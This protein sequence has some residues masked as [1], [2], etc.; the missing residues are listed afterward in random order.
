MR[1][2]DRK[3]RNLKPLAPGSIP[4]SALQQDISYEDWTPEPQP[5]SPTTSNFPNTTDSPRTHVSFIFFFF[6]ML[7]KVTGIRKF[8]PRN[9]N[10]V[11]LLISCYKVFIRKEMSLFDEYLRYF[12]CVYS[13]GTATNSRPPGGVSRWSF[14]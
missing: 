11:F 6:R 3:C 9:A 14:Q 1:R 12:L 8:E 4:L 5:H 13:T 7:N 2:E 10:D